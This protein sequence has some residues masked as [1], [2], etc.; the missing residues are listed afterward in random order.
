MVSV[1][2]VAGGL[3]RRVVKAI[4][5]G[6]LIPFLMLVLQALQ[7]C[8]P[9]G[10]EAAEALRSEPNR[11]FNGPIFRTWRKSDLPR[12]SYRAYRDAIHEQRRTADTDTVRALFAEVKSMR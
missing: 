7:L 2:S 11:R 12:G 1:R 5:I 3:N 10:E 6:S 9:S 8:Y 4:P